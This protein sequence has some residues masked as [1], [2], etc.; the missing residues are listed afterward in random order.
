MEMPE[1]RVPREFVEQYPTPSTEAQE[2]DT[3]TR[4]DSLYVGQGEHRVLFFRY[5]D[6]EQ[7][8]R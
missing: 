1:E 7:W 3:R 4:Q 5:M 8:R 2:T 6:P